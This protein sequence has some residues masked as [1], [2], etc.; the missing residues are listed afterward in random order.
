MKKETQIANPKDGKSAKKRH[1]AAYKRRIA[2]GKANL[3]RFRKNPRTAA[4]T[5]GIRSLIASGGE[6]MPPVPGAEEIRAEVDGLVAEMISDLGGKTEVTAAQK[7]ILR[8]QRL[9]LLVVGLA[10]SYLS[11]EG[12]INTKSGKPHALLSVCATYANAARLNALALGLERRAR[13]VG[14]ANLQEYLEQKASE[15]EAPSETL[16]KSQANETE[17]SQ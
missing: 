9:C 8:S 3:L 12:L 16:T 7:T 14:P 4:V 2:V 17:Q 10:S 1:S 13:K 6:S 11:R 15:H 5:H